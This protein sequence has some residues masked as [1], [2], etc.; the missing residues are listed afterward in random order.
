M[1]A[2]AL[3]LAWL[4]GR[5]RRKL[6]DQATTYVVEQL[7]RRSEP[8]VALPPEPAG[9]RAG[10]APSPS[11]LRMAARDEIAAMVERQPEEVAAAAP[12][13]AGRGG[14]LR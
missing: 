6:R 10:A 13:L 2:A 9:R 5:K 4:R 11:Q 14:P 7:R 8:T 3:L 1:I 12:R